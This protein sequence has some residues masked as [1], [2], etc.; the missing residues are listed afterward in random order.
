MELTV[1]GGLPRH[2]GSAGAQ[3]GPGAIRTARRGHAVGG[4]P[5]RLAATAMAR[6]A[7]AAPADAA[8][9]AAAAMAAAAATAA[10]AVG[11]RR[12]PDMGPRTRCRPRAGRAHLEA[13]LRACTRRG[14]GVRLEHAR[15]GRWG[16]L[17]RGSRD[18]P[19]ID[20]QHRRTRWGGRLHRACGSGHERDR[21]ERRRAASGQQCAERLGSAAGCAQRRTRHPKPRHGDRHGHHGDRHWH[22]RSAGR[23]TGRVRWSSRR[24][25]RHR[26]RTRRRHPFLHD[27]G[28]PDDRGHHDRCHDL[29]PADRRRS[30][31]CHG[32]LVG[33][34]HDR[35]RPR[36]WLR[37]WS[38][39]ARPG[40]P[41]ASAAPGRGDPALPLCPPRTWRSCCRRKAPE[42]PRPDR[43]PA[44]GARVAASVA[45]A[46]PAPC[47]PS[48]TA[49]SASRR[50]PG[51]PWTWPRPTPRPTTG[52]RQR[53]PMP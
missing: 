33:P 42:P 27:R 5:A 13:T 49:A 39:V 17:C 1:T 44:P 46:S 34:D 37:R 23:R 4:R 50:P 32:R 14:P 10:M 19:G 21:S 53:P 25:D 31:R 15:G 7:M 45:A 26:V 11:R 9:A 48:V 41:A 22:R 38:G 3:P 30:G 51:R 35:R 16:R 43:G 6:A 52:R 8:A 47:P 12:E 24:P 29:S 18:G 20:R 36:C 40:R 28:R 2:P